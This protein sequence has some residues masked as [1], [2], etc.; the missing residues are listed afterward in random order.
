MDRHA[1]TVKLTGEDGLERLKRSKVLILGV[2]GVGSYATEV[3]GRTAVGSITLMDG[4]AVSES[5][6]NRQLVA[7]CSTVGRNKAEVAA[8]RLRDINPDA[9]ITAIAEFYEKSGDVDVSKYDFVVDAIDDVNAK[10]ELIRECVRAKVPVVSS[11]GAAGKLGTN[12][13]VE[14]LAK[15]GTCPLARVVRKRLREYGIEHIP[16]VYSREK[17][18]PRDGELGSISY[19]PAAAGLVLGGYVLRCLAG[20]EEN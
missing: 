20:L 8:E 2:G 4:D 12:F 5:N 18:I 9:E 16:V 19:V 7:L 11:M 3:I 14:D 13:E 1:R 6:I 15:T 10:V 17:P